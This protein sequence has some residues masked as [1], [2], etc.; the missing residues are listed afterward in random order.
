MTASARRACDGGQR[1]VVAAD[2]GARAFRVREEEEVVNRD[3]L[4]GARG[5]E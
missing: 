2:F 4:R 5:P 3:D 1:R